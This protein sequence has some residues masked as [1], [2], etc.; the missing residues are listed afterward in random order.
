MII[1]L[2]KYKKSK[3][4]VEDLQSIIYTL[5]NCYKD[6]YRYR[7]YK[8][9]SD[10]LSKL[11]AEKALLKLYYKKYKLYLDSKGTNNG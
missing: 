4:I 8:P 3:I 10:L 11:K 2:T 6:L 9:I 5:E 1:D 7:K